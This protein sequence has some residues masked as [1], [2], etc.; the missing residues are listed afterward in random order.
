MSLFN[1]FKKSIKIQ[2]EVFGELVLDSYEDPSLN[3]YTGE[4]Y[5]NEDHKKVGFII[6][7]GDSLPTEA[8]HHFY[9]Q[10]QNHFELL[11]QK[12]IPLITNVFR[13]RMKDFVIHD[14]NREFS[15]DCITIPKQDNN[16]QTWEIS[17]ITIHD[18]D[19]WVIV[20]FVGFEPVDVMIDG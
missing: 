19:H 1:R 16:L 3:V 6:E 7:T 9:S 18:P 11:T 13:N 12:M 20:D 15:M 8:C 4:G 2:D 10:V 14:F 17:F 5:F